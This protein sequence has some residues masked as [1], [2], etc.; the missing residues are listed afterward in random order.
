MVTEWFWPKLSSGP[1]KIELSDRRSC[2]VLRAGRGKLAQRSVAADEERPGRRRDC[3]VGG[4]LP[5][6]DVA[7]AP[8]KHRDGT[9]LVAQFEYTLSAP[10]VV[11]EERMR[12]SPDSAG[13]RTISLPRCP[14]SYESQPSSLKVSRTS[15]KHRCAC[16]SH[17]TCE[18]ASA[19]FRGQDVVRSLS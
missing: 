4:S 3:A 17:I 11:C 13:S 5:R 6:G 18:P 8:D 19:N 14:G 15:S 1:E 7:R 10:G 12:Y 16:R 9:T 2:A